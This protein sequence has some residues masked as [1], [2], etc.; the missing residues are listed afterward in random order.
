[1]SP[2]PWRFRRVSLGPGIP[3]VDVEPL[4]LPPSTPAPAP[5]KRHGSGRALAERTGWDVLVV[6]PGTGQEGGRGRVAVCTHPKL[7]GWAAGHRKR[8]WALAHAE[9]ETLIRFAA[10]WQAIEAGNRLIAAGGLGEVKP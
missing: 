9:S 8:G 5:A 4:D 1:M 2:E 10:L 6:F 3:Q 7:P